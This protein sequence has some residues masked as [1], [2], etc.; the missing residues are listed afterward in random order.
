MY[1]LASHCQA[2]EYGPSGMPAGLEPAG[3]E[4]QSLCWDCQRAEWECLC[5]W[6]AERIPGMK[7]QP[8]GYNE[9]GERLEVVTFCPAYWPEP[10]RGCEL[11]YL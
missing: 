4:F 8:N 10:D 5:P 3:E 9:L 7:T 11:G 2:G 1:K 6:P